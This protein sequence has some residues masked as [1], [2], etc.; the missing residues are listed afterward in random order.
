MNKRSPIESFDDM[1]SLEPHGIDVLVGDSL[2]YPWGRVY[3]GQ[4]VAQALTAALTTVE[5]RYRP[6][7]LHGYFIR[8]G[9]SDEPIRYEV[10]RI[11]NGRSF[12]TRRVVARQSTG[13]IFNLSASFHADE[14]DLDIQTHDLPD[15]VPMPD[16][17]DDDSWTPLIQ[18]RRV[19]SEFADGRTATWLR[20]AEPVGDAPGGHEVA[21]AFL[22]DD[23]PYEAAASVHPDRDPDAGEEG[24]E[25][26]VGASLDHSMWFHR[27][28]ASDDWQLHILGA[29]GY[30][31]NRGLATGQVLGINGTH[32]A[33]VAQEVVLR[34]NNSLP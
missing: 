4:V 27:P 15:G 12:T 14:G 16:D 33:T 28:A 7:S 21:L 30:R 8:T 25:L 6:H 31:N 29:D 5:E 3:G 32:M 18:R 20:L 23:A 17:L 9:T 26:F 2:I 19:P 22:S 13:A 1:M 11:R 10:D 24:F 34:R